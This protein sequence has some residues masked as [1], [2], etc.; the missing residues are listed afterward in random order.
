M[1][2]PNFEL[3]WTIHRWILC[4][5]FSYFSILILGPYYLYHGR[6]N[7]AIFGPPLIQV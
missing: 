3:I 2:G 7:Q 6:A 4:L 5:K 1:W